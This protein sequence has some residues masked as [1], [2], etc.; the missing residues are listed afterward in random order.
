MG[1]SLF[2]L[3]LKEHKLQYSGKEEE[4]EASHRLEITL[5]GFYA[6]NYG[7][8]VSLIA[9]SGNL[10]EGE[11]RNTD[12]MIEHHGIASTFQL[13]YSRINFK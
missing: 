1:S 10:A 8:L 3:D 6:W 5:R 11:T 2:I 13:S 4:R 9:P 7:Q 12:H